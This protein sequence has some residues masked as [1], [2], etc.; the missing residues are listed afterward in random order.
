MRKTRSLLMILAACLMQALPA[1]AEQSCAAASLQLTASAPAM[2]TLALSAPCHKGKALSLSHAGLQLDARTDDQG[3]LTLVLPALATPAGV[4]VIWADGSRLS[5]SI[6][7]TDF[8]S[9]QRLALQPL[10]AGGLHLSAPRPAN[11]PP[12]SAAEPG[13]TEDLA[14]GGFLTL[15]GDP[16]RAPLAEV[17]TLPAATDRTGVRL[18]AQADG[19]NCGHDRL[20][21]LLRSQ[22]EG[23]PTAG[24]LA[25]AM[26]DCTR[27]GKQINMPLDS[28]PLPS[29]AP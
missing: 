29:P 20:A 23:A 22:P 14:K 4:T 12:I 3:R 6:P 24:A 8:A 13:R 21:M 25:L 10:G 26:P 1:R 7:L 9:V 2:V 28:L 19:G 11:R 17:L 18:T 27:L 16:A 15:L 5:A